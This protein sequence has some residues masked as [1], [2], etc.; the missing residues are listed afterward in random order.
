MIV[1]ISFLTLSD[2]LQARS[3]T[4]GEEIIELETQIAALIDADSSTSTLDDKL[5]KLYRENVKICEEVQHHL[6]CLFRPVSCRCSMLLKRRAFPR[7]ANPT[8]PIC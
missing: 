7:K 4:I 6:V 5:E 1:A 3:N 8:A 2:H